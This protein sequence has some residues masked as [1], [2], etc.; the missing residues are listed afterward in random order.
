VVG[1]R[2]PG[3]VRCEHRNGLGGIMGDLAEL[4][5]KL[6]VAKSSFM[7]SHVPGFQDEFI[8]TRLKSKA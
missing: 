4:G 3:I 5:S 7:E 8:A 6:F 2:R 1:L